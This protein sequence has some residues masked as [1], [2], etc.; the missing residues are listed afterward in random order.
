MAYDL[1]MIMSKWMKDKGLVF[2]K[3]S[4]HK[5]ELE[6]YTRKLYWDTLT[7]LYILRVAI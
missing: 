4:I 1:V 3:G 6:N 2:S 7:N 5:L